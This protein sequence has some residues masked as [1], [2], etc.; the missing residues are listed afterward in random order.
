MTTHSGTV[1][2][3]FGELWCGKCG[4]KVHKED[5]E[6]QANGTPKCPRCGMRLR[7]SARRYGKR[8]RKS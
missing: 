3:G 1:N 4:R 2:Y 5:S 8:G 6:T 7:V